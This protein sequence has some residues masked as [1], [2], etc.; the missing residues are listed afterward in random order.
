MLVTV[1]RFR[2]PWEAEMFRGRLEAEGIPAFVIH[3]RLIAMNW[4]WSVALG[5]A[6]V[7]VL[8]ED[9]MDAGDVVARCRSGEFG[10]VL[11][12]MFGYLGEPQCPRCGSIDC[13]RRGTVADAVT[14]FLFAFLCS[15]VLPPSRWQR[16]C[17]NCGTEWLD[18]SRKGSVA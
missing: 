5:G 10:G 6:K 14:G 11:L 1:A 13:E 8:D 16:T 3:Q 4:S 2:D 15:I 17:R 9:A 7:Q 18:N 12:E